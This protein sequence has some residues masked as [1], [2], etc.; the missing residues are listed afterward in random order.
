MTNQEAY[1]NLCYRDPRYPDHADSFD[2]GDE[3]PTPR[4]DC[5]CENCHS[6][7]DELAV[8]ILKLKEAQTRQATSDKLFITEIINDLLPPI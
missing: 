7:R 3:V 2:G 8:E 6:G 4:E 5:Y 1:E